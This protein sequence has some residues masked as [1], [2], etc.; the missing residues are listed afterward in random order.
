MSYLGLPNEC[1]LLVILAARSRDGG[2]N[3]ATLGSLIVLCKE[4]SDLIK[5]SFPTIQTHYT[6]ILKRDN[7]LIYE[8]CRVIHRD[9]DLPAKVYINGAQ[10]WY[11][12]GLIH[13]DNPLDDPAIITGNGTQKWYKNGYMRRRS[14]T[15]RTMLPYFIESEPGERERLLPLDD[16]PTVIYASGVMKW[17]K[18]VVLTG[19]DLQEYKIV[20]IVHRSNDLP[21]VIYP[22]GKKEWWANGNI[23]R[24]TGP[25]IIEANGAQIWVR[26]NVIHRDDDLPAII[27][28]NGARVWYQYGV[29]RRNY[30]SSASAL[31]LNDDFV[32]QAIISASLYDPPS[33]V[34]ADGTQVWCKFPLI[35]RA[36]DLP[37][38][39]YSDGTMK[40]YIEG[41]RHR[42]GGL[43]AVVNANGSLEWWY[44]DKQYFV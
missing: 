43:P 25:A 32:G 11:R 6:M 27:E 37:A 4:V 18:S 22:S 38:M 30:V 26:R 28:A 15:D 9:D 8:F 21:A 17:K 7:C 33:I 1:K 16:P 40:W 42:N 44:D 13:R 14:I 20:E 2:V 24:D 10:K 23:H 29:I 31:S 3:R 35:H 19:V 34:G 36:G 12:Y 5:T 41:K 39:I